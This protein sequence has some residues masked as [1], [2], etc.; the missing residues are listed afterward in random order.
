MLLEQATEADYP[1]IIDLV[2]VAFRGAGAGASW[3]IEAGI[4]EGQ[5][6]NDS[7]LRE[8]LA[9]NPA[10][11]LLIHRDADRS[12]LG[13]VWLDP[14][15]DGTWYL[16]LLTIRPALQKQKLGSRLLVAAEAY[17]K[18]RGAHT[19][20]MTVLNVRYALM[21]WY[22]RRGYH[23]TGETKPFPYGDDRFGKPLRDDLE[24]V[25]FEKRLS[26]GNSDCSITSSS[27]PA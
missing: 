12:V 9:E 22:E 18:Q 14:D 21:E 15:Q 6:M 10:A 16:G 20:S 25:V 4:L 11:H 13:T 7:L 17:A 1:A 23:R 3:N 27:Q 2:N 5:R 24:F 26:P 8:D 19:I